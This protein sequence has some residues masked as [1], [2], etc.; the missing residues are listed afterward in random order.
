[1]HSVIAASQGQITASVRQGERWDEIQAHAL[2]GASSLS[3][4]DDVAVMMAAM[5]IFPQL[6][7]LTMMDPDFELPLDLSRLPGRDVFERHLT[8]SIASTRASAQGI[9]S[10]EWTPNRR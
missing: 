7:M 8:H 6:S 2:D 1:M 9:V 4:R 5:S 3:F 10:H